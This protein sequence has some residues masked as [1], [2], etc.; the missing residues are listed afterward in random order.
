MKVNFEGLTEKELWEMRNSIRNTRTNSRNLFMDEIL[1]KSDSILIEINEIDN[2]WHQRIVD[3]YKET[4][5]NSC[6]LLYKVF[7][8]KP[9]REELTL[10]NAILKHYDISPESFCFSK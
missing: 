1:K 10:H 6:N 4:Y 9:E 7:S 2:A 8:E 3:N 5:I